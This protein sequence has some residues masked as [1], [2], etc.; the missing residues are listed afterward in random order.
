MP[1]V[2]TIGAPVAPPAALSK[3]AVAV[4]RLL[5][6]YQQKNQER[7]AALGIQW[8]EQV[9]TVVEAVMAAQVLLVVLAEVIFH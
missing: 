4:V 9:E 6:F 3:A 2:T 1:P 8:A 5:L 7:A